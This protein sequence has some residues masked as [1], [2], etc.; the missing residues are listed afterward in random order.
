MWQL[1]CSLHRVAL[2]VLWDGGAED[3]AS[4]RRHRDGPLH[5]VLLGGPRGSLPILSVPVPSTKGTLVVGSSLP[6]WKS[7]LSGPEWERILP[8]SLFK[9][10]SLVCSTLRRENLASGCGIHL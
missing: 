3:L 4:M 6:S 8:W 5:A 2:R 1:L 7:V 9:G 10:P